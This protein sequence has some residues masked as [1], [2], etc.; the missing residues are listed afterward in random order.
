MSGTQIDNS[1]PP[2]A[3]S[4]NGAPLGT[5]LTQL[6]LADSIEPGAELSYQLCKIILTYHP[7]GA[8]IVDA[9][10]NLA[11]SKEREIKVPG[12][13]DRVAKAFIKEWQAMHT[14]MII[15]EAK[16]I[17]RAYGLSAVVMGAK[18]V[19][20]DKAIDPEKY[21]T[22]ELY[23]NVLDPL[24]VSGSP[25]VSQDPNASNFLKVTA[26]TAQAQTYHRSRVCV[27]MN[28]RPIY[29]QYTQSAFGFVGRSV[30]QRALYPLKSFVTSMKTDDMIS[31]KAGLLIAKMEQA[32]SFIDRTMQS[33]FGAKR[34]LLKSGETDNVLGIGI[35]EDITSLNLQN[36][37]GA[38]KF[39]RDNILKNIATAVDFP[40]KILDNETLVEGFGEGTEDAK[41]IARFIDRYREELRPLY[42]FFDLIVQYRAWNPEFFASMQKEF[43]DHYGRLNYKQ[44]MTVWQNTFEA[45][46]PSLLQEPD[47]ERVKTDDTKLRAIV[48][49]VAALMPFLDPDDQALVIQWAQDNINDTAMLFSAML[50][51]DIEAIKQFA[52]DK[53][54]QT[55][56]SRQAGLMGGQGGEDGEAGNGGEAAPKPPKPPSFGLKAAA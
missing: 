41:Q 49:V 8:K 20:S 6:L 17:S 2:S 13:P 7:L 32:G 54:D 35:T 30:Y 31:R 3:L 52:Q 28:E 10:T 15:H 46:W 26:I 56:E 23:F 12:H 43:P 1:T 19:D 5:P 45:V 21:A 37:D 44:A 24:N 33:L 16:R 34:A 51:L 50:N 39:A 9:P 18:G 11:Q 48:A 14:D 25:L 38:G 4:I 55:E 36:I 29:I 42:D 53:I 27:T 22:L 47:S 40:A